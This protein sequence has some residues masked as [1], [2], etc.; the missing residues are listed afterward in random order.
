MPKVAVPPPLRGPTRGQ[1]EIEVAGR[2]LLECIESAEASYPGFRAQLLNGD[3][4]VHTFIRVFV[5]GAAVA[6]TSLG[7]AVAD[8]D[9]VELLAAVAGG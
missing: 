8:G 5:N 1:A 9:Q 4:G 6:P 2:T 3:G 7:R